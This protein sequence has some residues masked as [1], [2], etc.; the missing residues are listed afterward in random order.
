MKRIYSLLI[1]ALFFS[2]LSGCSWFNP[3]HEMEKS[4]ETLASEGSAAFMDEDYH[5]AIESFTTLKDWYPF[6]RY[7]ILAEL[8]IADAHYEREEY[9]EAIFAYR[10]FEK[11]HPRNE[12]IPYVIYRRGMCWYNR[13]D[14]V[15][16]DQKSAKKSMAQF[17]RLKEQY[18]ESSYAQKAE[19]KTE[20][21]IASLAG[22]ELYVANFYLKKEEYRA[23]LKRF[24]YLFAH[25]PETK[26]GEQAL[27]HIPQCKKKIEK[28]Q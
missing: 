14:T 1:A 27:K 3:P 19:D 5:Q 9:A 26:E 12:A 2:S 16:R 4:A 18:P 17:N 15:D 23:A 10:E 6:S 8:K 13:I 21:C 22:H 25:Y 11:L 20:K 7:A 24:E 28:K